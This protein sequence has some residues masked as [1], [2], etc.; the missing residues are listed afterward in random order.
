M[1]NKDYPIKTENEAFHGWA[2]EVWEALDG[3]TDWNIVNGK[4]SSKEC[5][6]TWGSSE[7]QGKQHHIDRYKNSPVMHEAN[8]S[9]YKPAIFDSAG[10][11]V[12]FPGSTKALRKPR[13]KKQ[14]RT[15][16]TS[17][18]RSTKAED[19]DKGT[20]AG[21]VVNGKATDDGSGGGPG[22]EKT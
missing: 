21:S 1:G 22:N 18:T 9:S 4:K 12:E 19:D 16:C 13:T 3:F 2:V 7:H 14:P 17:P 11:M 5:E 6:V 8:Q 15:G 10:T 20:D